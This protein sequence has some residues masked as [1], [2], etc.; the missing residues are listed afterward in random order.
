MADSEAVTAIFISVL[1]GI[2]LSVFFDGV[3]IL[4]LVGFM[5]TYMTKPSQ[6]HIIVGILASLLVG[7]WIFIY[8]LLFV[9]PQ[10]PSEISV[11]IGV[12]IGGFISGFMVIC[13]ISIVLGTIGSFVATKVSSYDNQNS[14][15]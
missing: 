1:A 9:N 11:L 12:D 10:I 14:N 6:R 13:L 2:I 4:A 3:F 5:A 7:F 8:G 15:L